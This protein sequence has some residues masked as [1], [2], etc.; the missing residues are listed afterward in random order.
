MFPLG[1]GLPSRPSGPLFPFKDISDYNDSIISISCPQRQ[2][3]YLNHI[4]ITDYIFITQ[5]DKNRN[6]SYFC[7][8]LAM[9]LYGGETTLVTDCVE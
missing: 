9:L 8:S 7:L 1:P 2:Q 6:K 4:K 5:K 3:L